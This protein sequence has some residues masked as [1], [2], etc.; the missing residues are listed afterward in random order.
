MLFTIQN[1]ISE[2]RSIRKVTQEELAQAV[3][4]S[5]QTINALEKGNYIPSLVLAMRIS[6]YF[7]M[8]VEDVFSLINLNN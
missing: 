8:K 6:N 1:K 2:L 3:G 7:Q 4:V 5:R